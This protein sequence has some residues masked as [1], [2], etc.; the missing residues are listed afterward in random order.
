MLQSLEMSS[1]EVES[2]IN[3]EVMRIKEKFQEK[4]SELCPYPQK[5]QEAKVELE[6][7]KDKIEELEKD[8][9]ATLSV[10]CKSKSALKE[11]KQQQPDESLEKK[12]KKLQCEVEMLKAKHGG[13]KATKECL[14]EKLGSMKA[15]I[16]NLR[17]DSAKII[18]TTKCCADKNRQILH[19]HINGLEIDLAQCRASA[20]MTLAEKE[21]TIRKMKHE[22]AALCGHFNDCQGQIKQLKNH[23]TY[24]T[25]Q[26]HE[27]RPEDLNKI[28]FCSPE[29]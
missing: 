9:K 21:E 27:I 2:R 24:L 12:Y 20:A 5:Y 8:L 1:S 3:T 23:V 26:R 14:E 6:N 22:L 25:N 29:C 15:E 11:L 16:E 7:S 13:I 10:L 28:D 4:L 18:T 17:R 19:Q